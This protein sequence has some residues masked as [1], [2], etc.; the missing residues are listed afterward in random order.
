M[1]SNSSPREAAPE[2]APEWMVSF[3]DMVTI[4][5]AF[6]VVMFSMAGEKDPV[7][8]VEMVR[9]LRRHLGHWP[10]MP[11]G[12]LVPREMQLSAAT[13]KETAGGHLPDEQPLEGSPLGTRRQEI[14]VPTAGD[15]AAL[16]E[17]IFF[18]DEADEL[19]DDARRRL[20]RIIEHVRGKAQRIE[21]RAHA[22]RRP[23]PAGSPW[24]DHRDLAYARCRATLDY[25]VAKGIDPDR[26]RL[27]VDAMHA[28]P[29]AADEQLMTDKDCL[30]EVFILNEFMRPSFDRP[31]RPRNANEEESPTITPNGTTP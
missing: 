13:G 6:F 19:T 3:A 31:L 2:G 20:D 14:H 21:V 27:G 12:A 1:S 30:I 24:R 8:E 23:L 15:Q 9:S 10:M 22:T 25:L 5:M 18:F 17:K 28:Q 16:G 26:I 29:D 11:V 7:K 4:L